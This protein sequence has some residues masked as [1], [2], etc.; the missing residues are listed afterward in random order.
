MLK[1]FQ[2]WLQEQNLSEKQT[3]TGLGIFP[4][5]YLVG[6]YPPLALTPASSTA[7]LELTTIHKGTVDKLMKKN[8]KKK[9]K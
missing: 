9:D 3:R 7:A 2:Q 6:Q 5:L 1:S 8:K 4:P